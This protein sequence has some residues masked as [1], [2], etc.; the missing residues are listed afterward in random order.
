MNTC[1]ASTYSVPGRAV[2]T[3]ESDTDIFFPWGEVRMRSLTAANQI[4]GMLEGSEHH[5]TNKRENRDTDCE[6]VGY[7]F[8]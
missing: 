4:S 8:K 2:I 7:S 1:A 3:A 5:K 6:R